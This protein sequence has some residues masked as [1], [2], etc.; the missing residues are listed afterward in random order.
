MEAKRKAYM[1]EGGGGGEKER[2]REGE[3]GRE[4]HKEALYSSSHLVEQ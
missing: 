4:T 3:K 2:R 1:K